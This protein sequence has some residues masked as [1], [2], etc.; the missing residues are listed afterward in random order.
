M[1]KSANCEEEDT[2]REW[3]GIKACGERQHLQKV[4]DANLRYSNSVKALWGAIHA[5][6]DKKTYRY[7]DHLWATI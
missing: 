3:R 1:V 5:G 6:G 4:V 2:V 7:G